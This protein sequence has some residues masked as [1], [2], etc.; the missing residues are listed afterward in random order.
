MYFHGTGAGSKLLTKPEKLIETQRYSRWK[1][2]TGFAD[3]EDL[4][5][6]IFPPGYCEIPIEHFEKMMPYPANASE[7]FFE[8]R[9][10]SLTSWPIQMSQN[11]FKMA[12]AGWYYTGY[13]DLAKTFCCGVSHKGWEKNQDPWVVHNK[14]SIKD[15]NSFC[16]LSELYK[17]GVERKKDNS[18][19]TVWDTLF[20]PD[21]V[22]MIVFNYPDVDKEHLANKVF[23]VYNPSYLAYYSRLNSFR[24]LWNK[25]LRPKPKHLAEAGFFYDNI[26]DRCVTFCCGAVVDN[27]K[28]NVNPIFPTLQHFAANKNC[29]V[30][31]FFK[32]YKGKVF[33]SFSFFL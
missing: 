21:Y 24:G 22:G 18:G 29:L 26:G 16:A 30:L 19:T 17:Q 10:N 20:I 13:S 5:A 33:W 11:K 14:K 27:W 8:D 23:Q 15:F 12:Q 25:H 2:E 4:G 7:A 3:K 32:Y 9:M 31:P 1:S 6:F 28:P